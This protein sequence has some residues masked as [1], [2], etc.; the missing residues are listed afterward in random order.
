MDTPDTASSGSGDLLPELKSKIIFFSNEFPNDDVRD[1]FR[2]LHR[3]AKDK[4]FALLAAFL[5]ESAATIKEEASRLPR[6]LQDL[7]PSFSSVLALA[8]HGEFRHGPLGAAM[9]SALLTILE[10]GMFIG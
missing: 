10:I 3:H 9:E 2:Q 5:E 6:P 1:L 4:R 8:D 7:I